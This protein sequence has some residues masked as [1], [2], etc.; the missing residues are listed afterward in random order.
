MKN[1]FTRKELNS[2]RKA[3]AALAVRD[4]VPESIV[5]EQITE[6]IKAA[7][8]N[9]DPAVQARWKDTPFDGAAPTPEEFIA[10]CARE[11]KDRAQELA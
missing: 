11:V 2:A 1:N 4:G 7:M 6:A 10:L 9:P 3:I 8:E 5:R